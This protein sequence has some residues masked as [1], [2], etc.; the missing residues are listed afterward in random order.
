[1]NCTNQKVRRAKQ[2]I[3]DEKYATEQKKLTPEEKAAYKKKIKLGTQ[4]LAAAMSVVTMTNG[5]YSKIL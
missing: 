2:R 5:P 3:A 4:A 1:M